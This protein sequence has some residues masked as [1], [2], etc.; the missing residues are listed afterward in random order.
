MQEK[1]P[2]R[3]FSLFQNKS[4][5][6]EAEIARISALLKKISNRYFG[7]L[8]QLQADLIIQKDSFLQ[9]EQRKAPSKEDYLIQAE[10]PEAPSEEQYLGSLNGVYFNLLNYGI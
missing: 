1:K 7:E 10:Q 4:K 8:I 2:F 3:P 5:S 9:S 6:R